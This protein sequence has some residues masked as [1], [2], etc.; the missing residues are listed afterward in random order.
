MTAVSVKGGVS[1]SGQCQGCVS[2]SGQCQGW[3][4]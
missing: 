3:C 2:D 4:E 1:D